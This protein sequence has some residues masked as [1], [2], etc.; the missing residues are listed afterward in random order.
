MK[1]CWI[2][3]HV[4][5]MDES[6]K[7]YHELLGLK[8]SERF[9]AGEGT[10]I[11]MLG[12]QDKP[13]IELICSEDNKVEVQSNGISIGFEVDSLDKAIEYVKENN[14]SIKRGP[15]SPIPTTRFFF[16]DDPNGIEIQLV[17]HK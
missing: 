7:F 10:E 5:N 8:I 11:V 13:K 4:K 12:E 16:I 9:N 1:F 15:I 6:L 3:L 14:I 2:T 17:E